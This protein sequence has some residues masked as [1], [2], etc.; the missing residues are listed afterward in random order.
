MRRWNKPEVRF[1]V[2]SVILLILDLLGVFQINIPVGQD[3]FKIHLLWWP[4]VLSV[5]LIFAKLFE[6]ILDNMGKYIERV[7][8]KNK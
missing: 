5:F 6:Y 4:I 2:F 1:I 3:G 8:S 7:S